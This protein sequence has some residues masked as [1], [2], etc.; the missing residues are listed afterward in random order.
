MNPIQYIKESCTRQL[1]TAPEDFIG[2]TLAY[3]C[4]REFENEFTGVDLDDI[5]TIAALVNSVR[6]MTWRQF[7]AF[8]WNGSQAVT[9]QNIQRLMEQWYGYAW[10]LGPVDA[11]LEFERIHPFSDGNGRVGSLLFNLLNDTLHDPIHPPPYHD[12]HA[13]FTPNAPGYTVSD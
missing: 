4:I 7:P 5:R 3:S 1:A 8:F 9:P 6:E 10:N 13:V 2:M 12:P 11:Y